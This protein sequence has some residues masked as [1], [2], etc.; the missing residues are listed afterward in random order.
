MASVTL[1]LIG[2][3]VRAAGGRHLAVVA[4]LATAALI[5]VVVSASAIVTADGALGRGLSGLPA[6]E[7]SVI[8]SHNGFLDAT[9]SASADT[10]ARRELRTL[11]T[12]PVR[13]E[14]AF[15]ELAD[16]AGQSFVL[17]GADQLASAVRV[18]SGRLPRTCTPARCEVLA[19]GVRGQAPVLRSGYGLVV[20][21]QGVRTD[22]LLLTG[23]FDP[24]ANT[25]LIGDGVDAV[26]ANQPLGLIQR[27]YGWVAPLDQAQI[28]DQGVE[29]W[30]AAAIASAD[31]LE[32]APQGLALTTPDSVIRD[33]ADRADLSAGRFGLLAGSCAVLLLGAALVGGAALRPNQARFVTALRR[34]G[35][36]ELRIR[37]VVAGEA[38]L[39]S[40]VALVAGLLLGVGAAAVQL[41]RGGLPIGSSLGPVLTSALAAEGLLAVAAFGLLM[42]TLWPRSARPAPVEQRAGWRSLTVAVLAGL[43]AVGLAVSRGGD[44][45]GGS[46]PLLILLP[47]LV[48][49][50]VGLIAAR[51]WPWAL[52]A[53][54]RV[55]PRRMVGPRLGIAGIAARPLLAAATV[56]LLAAAVGAT[57]FAAS[58]RSTLLRGAAD[59]ATFVVPLDARIQPG[60][61]LTPVL[62]Q[63][64]AAGYRAVAP[65]ATVEPVLRQAGAIRAGSQQAEVV[66]FVGV[67]PAALPLIRRWPDVVG[68]SSPGAVA[69]AVHVAV[70]AAGVVLPAGRQVRIA[71]GAPLPLIAVTAWVQADDGRQRSIDLTADAA[72]T[73]LTGALPAGSAGTGPWS[74]TELSLSQPVDQA[75]H[76]QHSLGESTTSKAVPA[77]RIDLG[78]LS[79]DGGDPVARPWSGWTATGLVVSGEGA[80]AV[81]DYRLIASTLVATA[82]PAGPGS[83]ESGLPLPVAADPA[84]AAD[85]PLITLTLNG[86][87]VP[88]RVVATLDRFPTVSGRFVLADRSAL[89][90]LLS[91][92]TPGAGQ[93]GELWL[94]LPPAAATTARTALAGPAFGGLQ[95]QWAA[96]LEQGLRTDPVA[97]GAI[98]LLRL[99][100]YLTMVV[101]LAALVLLVVGER[102]E[103]ADELYAWEANGVQPR[104]LR[105][106]LW[107][108]A[109]LVAVLAVPVGVVGGLV[110]TRLT[111]R[112]VDITAG[113]QQAQP[114]LVALTGLATALPT[115]LIAL[116]L[117]LV[118][119]GVVALSSFRAPLPAPSTGGR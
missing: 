89:A 50:T 19:I 71:L 63:A 94:N 60:S 53:G 64:S 4:A 62:T 69:G 90:A 37:L 12:L 87:A 26:A 96:D 39:I 57:G 77:G 88:A 111:A 27:A 116:A 41:G 21:G 108:R 99:V 47:A 68:R 45:T 59:Q 58:Y 110:L 18:T 42:L 55:L 36:R 80:R 44:A 25:V 52:Q 6:G 119:S 40:V 73:T 54:F 107:V 20:V 5:P 56:G 105:Q 67:D 8:V 103:D 104:A 97:R 24:G 101:A 30:I 29:H 83:A 98:S 92:T 13:R 86:V 79:V 22:P 17:A 74:L 78:G 2:S 82:R 115:V 106:G 65:G 66:Q 51:A 46:D 100:A 32:L 43:V 72:G 75:T 10:V 7:R 102:I 33:Q 31:R 3:R 15:K 28:R 95:V 49:L 35:L 16:S 91:R 118:V 85:G 117:A 84:T 114:P 1:A 48:L 61:G 70:R 34:R 38:A 109:V 14:V 112:L 113:A 11:V 76:R 93:P 23:A 81:L 9:E